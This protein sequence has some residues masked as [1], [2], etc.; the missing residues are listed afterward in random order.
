MFRVSTLALAATVF[1][2]AD[3]PAMYQLRPQ[4][5]FLGTA[6][7]TQNL[8]V[9][10]GLFLAV[11][12]KDAQKDVTLRQ[13][14]QLS[15]IRFVSGEFARAVRPMPAAK[16][17]FQ[18]PAGKPVDEKALHEALMR[19]G[20]AVTVGTTVQITKVDFLQKEIRVEING[21]ARKKRPLR[22][23]IK[24]EVGVPLPTT[25]V[26]QPGSTEGATSQLPG[27]TLILDYGRPLPDMSPDDLK[28]DLAVFLDFSK[29]RSA[30]VQWVDSL[31]PEYK[32]AI[33]DRKAAVGMDREMVTAA[34]GRP[35]R[36]VREKNENGDETEDW[37][38]GQPPAKTVFVTFI[39]DKVVRVKEFP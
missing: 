29:E 22:Q 17:G 24:V 8:P 30:A 12:Q 9:L 35:D 25:S 37:I 39:G 21:G 20:A 33:K 4:T 27:A 32:A 14:S 26:S 10:P 28:R 11:G 34:L 5:G 13:Q 15:I 23:R 36:K 18:F 6:P 1:V 3:I 2:L 31:P 38:Y 7:L 19:F 16:K